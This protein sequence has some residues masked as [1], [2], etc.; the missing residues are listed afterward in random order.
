MNNELEF[1]KVRFTTRPESVPYFYRLSYRVA[2]T[3][4]ILRIACR[5]NS[6]CSLTK[7]HL[8]VTTMFSE[9]ETE[10][11]LKNISNNN[12][13]DIT[14][15]FDSTVNTTVEFLLAEQLINLTNN[16][17]FLLTKSGNAFVDSILSDSKILINEK[18]FLNKL[19]S[20]LTESKIK[21]ISNQ[22]N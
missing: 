6:S 3:C 21:Q 1:S 20:K 8:I 16:N 2:I 10:K 5:K 4:L 12:L 15:R 11:L 9:T 17:Q 22:I 7:L 18:A 19:G 13:A 14:L